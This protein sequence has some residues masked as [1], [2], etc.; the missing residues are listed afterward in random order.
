MGAPLVN[1]I[2]A[3]QANVP[4]AFITLPLLI[5]HPLQLFVAGLLSP[6]LKRAC[7]WSGRGFQS[8]L[9]CIVGGG[10][11]AGWVHKATD[12]GTGEGDGDGALLMQTFAADA[13]GDGEGEGEGGT[14]TAVGQAPAPMPE[15]T[16]PAS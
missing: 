11:G 6:P 16:V 12:D 7:R 9:T 3:G 4:L 14:D 10:G 5:L 13:D 1:V 15:T 2:F 8:A